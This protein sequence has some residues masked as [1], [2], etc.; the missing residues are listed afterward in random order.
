MHYY[1]NCQSRQAQS[2]GLRYVLKC[3]REVHTIYVHTAIPE[4]N[5]IVVPLVVYVNIS[6]KILLTAVQPSSY[7][8]DRFNFFCTFFSL[9]HLK[10]RVYAPLMKERA[11]IRMSV[12]VHFFT[13]LLR[14]RNS[15]KFVFLFNFFMK[16]YQT[17]LD[18]VDIRLIIYGS[19]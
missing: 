14:G 7:D 15:C 12:Q 2:K 16:A 10:C 4:S 17:D 3:Y 5:D 9:M 13:Q 18:D 6:I 1:V 19:N 11:N 8:N